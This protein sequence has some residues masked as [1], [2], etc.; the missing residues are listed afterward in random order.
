MRNRL[1]SLHDE[2]GLLAVRDD[3]GRKRALGVE[4]ELVSAIT[5]DLDGHRHVLGLGLGV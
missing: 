4:L 1:E 2:L 3:E 5:V